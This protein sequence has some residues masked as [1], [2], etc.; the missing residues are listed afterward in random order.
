MIRHSKALEP[1]L[2]D[3]VLLH[4]RKTSQLLLG[5]SMQAWQRSANR[6]PTLS[7]KELDFM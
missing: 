7:T 1:W 5:P 3:P 4:G 2:P 6:K